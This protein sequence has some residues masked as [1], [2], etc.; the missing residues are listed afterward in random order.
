[1]AKTPTQQALAPMKLEDLH[2][3]IAWDTVRSYGNQLQVFLN[4]EH[5][6]LVLREQIGVSPIDENLPTGVATKN[7]ASWVVPLDVA[8]QLGKVLTGLDFE[9]VKN[10]KPDK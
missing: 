1:M 7:I 9:A 10:A 6:L 5:A 3:L 4:P 8:E 2:E